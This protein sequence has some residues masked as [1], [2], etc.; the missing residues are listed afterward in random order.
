ML[1]KLLRSGY[2]QISFT[3]LSKWW[4]VDFL[5]RPVLRPPT[6]IQLAAL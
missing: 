4:L 1:A 5:P 6:L 2:S 3:G